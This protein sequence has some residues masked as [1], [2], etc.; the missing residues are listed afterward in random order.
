MTKE[1]FLKELN[2]EL[3]FENPLEMDTNIKNH[4]E[5]DSLGAMIL[6]SFVSKKFSINLNQ[7]ELQ[8]ISTVDSLFDKIGQ[9]KFK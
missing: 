1:N 6:L 3:E 8:S 7:E 2:E 4:E 5:W 9:E